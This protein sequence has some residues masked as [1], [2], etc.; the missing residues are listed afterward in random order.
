MQSCENSGALSRE[1]LRMVEFYDPYAY[2]V[3]VEFKKVQ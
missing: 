2:S 3:Q 1:V